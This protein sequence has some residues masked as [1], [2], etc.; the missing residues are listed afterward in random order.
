MVDDLPLSATS[1]NRGSET[2]WSSLSTTSETPCTKSYCIVSCRHVLLDKGLWHISECMAQFNQADNIIDIDACP[3]DPTSVNCSNPIDIG[4]G[5]SALCDLFEK[6]QGLIA[7][8][9][10]KCLGQ[11]VYMIGGKSGFRIGKFGGFYLDTEHGKNKRL[12][13]IQWMSNEFSQPGDSGSLVFFKHPDLDVCAPVG[14]LVEQ[15][16]GLRQSFLVPFDEVEYH[17]TNKVLNDT[18]SY[19]DEECHR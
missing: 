8:L 17:L 5:Y 14:I 12:L 15:N 7:Y 3:F 11:L 6:D 16:K 19:M 2:S 4:Y 13:T 9:V 18:F 1:G 10:D